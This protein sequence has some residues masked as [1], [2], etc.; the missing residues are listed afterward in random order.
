MLA[1]ALQEQGGGGAWIKQMRVLRAFRLFRLFGKMGQLKRIVTAVALSIVPTLQ[2]LVRGSVVARRGWGMWRSWVRDW[3]GAGSHRDLGWSGWVGGIEEQV[4][5]WM[6]A[7]N[8]GKWT[9]FLS[10]KLI[11]N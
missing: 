2:A 6:A 11:L 8:A 5:K 10:L 4:I 1:L 7:R 9:L 3:R